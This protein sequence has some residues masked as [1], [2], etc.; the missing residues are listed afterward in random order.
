MSDC[1]RAGEIDQTQALDAMEYMEKEEN[2]IPW[3]ALGYNIAYMNRMLQYEEASSVPLDV[4]IY[5]VV[6]FYYHN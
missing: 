5:N 1:F 3:R 4:C 2:Y 6:L